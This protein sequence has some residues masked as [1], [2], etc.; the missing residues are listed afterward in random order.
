M[1]RRLI[2]WS[3]SRPAAYF[4][5]PLCRIDSCHQDTALQTQ[6]VIDFQYPLCRIDSCHPRQCRFACPFHHFSIRSVGSIHATS[7]VH[8][9][10]CSYSASFS[11]RSVGSIHATYE[12]TCR[13]QFSCHALSVSAL[14]DRFMPLR[15]FKCPLSAYKL[16]VSALSDR[17]MPL[18]VVACWSFLTSNFQ[19]PLCR[20]DSCHS[21]PASGA[22]HAGQPSFS[23]RSVGSI[24]ATMNHAGDG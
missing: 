15:P 7:D 17:F 19:Y 9:S 8:A 2:S 5:Y 3:V 18:S 10:T 1:P 20:I 11:I 4:Q 21:D 14:S 22:L 6:Q 12:R 23:I 16:S 24:H 13:R